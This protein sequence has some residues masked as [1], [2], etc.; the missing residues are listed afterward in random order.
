MNPIFRLGQV[1]AAPQRQTPRSGGGVNLSGVAAEAQAAQN[2][3]FAVAAEEAKAAGLARA[4]ERIASAGGGVVD[5]IKPPRMDESGYIAKKAEY[6]ALSNA[7]LAF[8]ASTLSLGLGE[9]KRRAESGDGDAEKF[10]ENYA[11]GVLEGVADPANK[12]TLAAQSGRYAQELKFGIARMVS[13][14]AEM[15]ARGRDMDDIATLAKG[16]TLS[17][18]QLNRG[19]LQA[20]YD[21]LTPKQQMGEYG[22]WVK[23]QLMEADG[24][25]VAS[26]PKFVDDRI[27]GGI[28]VND[29]VREARDWAKD[30]DEDSGYTP[31]MIE[32]AVRR[33]WALKSVGAQLNAVNEAFAK[34]IMA[35]GTVSEEERLAYDS[36]ELTAP[37][38]FAEEFKQWQKA[39]GD[40]LSFGK[41]VGKLDGD[42]NKQINDA[43]RRTEG[44]Y[45]E[46]EAVR[47]KQTEENIG[48]YF[49]G[50]SNPGAR[51]QP[52]QSRETQET[53]AANYQNEELNEDTRQK[54]AL[55]G[56]L[57]PQVYAAA[58]EAGEG[59]TGEEWD[60][61]VRTALTLNIPEHLAGVAIQ[62]KDHAAIV[63]MARKDI[64]KR[65][66][67]RGDWDAALDP[68]NERIGNALGL[69]FSKK[70]DDVAAGVAMVRNQGTLTGVE[71]MAA[72]NYLP[73]LPDGD[74]KE[75]VRDLLMREPGNNG[76]S[77]AMAAMPNTREPEEGDYNAS[78]T[79]V[80]E[81]GVFRD[82]PMMEHLIAYTH[83]NAVGVVGEKAPAEELREE[84]ARQ[85]NK[86][87][88]I[89]AKPGKFGKM[90]QVVRVKIF[91]NQ[92]YSVG[93]EMGV[94][95]SG[96]IETHAIIGKRTTAVG[97]NELTKMAFQ[98]RVA[99][100]RYQPIVAFDRNDPRAQG[101]FVFGWRDTVENAI[102]QME[103]GGRFYP[104]VTITEP[105]AILPKTAQEADAEDISVY[106]GLRM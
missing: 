20:K 29:M 56:L 87:P 102:V 44:L 48:N 21:G 96:A 71:R 105:D 34:K 92:N 88:A 101:N 65:I 51:A 61:A 81:N 85:L 42:H 93:T 14:R 32:A 52:A 63:E 58:R 47:K 8:Y 4:A 30:L 77:L 60:E 55:I 89:T 13:E 12:A 97:E 67:Q 72:I 18:W 46:A 78:L 7:N 23:K 91:P 27:A 31:E 106:A 76:F 49:V 84:H 37:E 22:K 83:A 53:L 9:A 98:E 24:F 95:A 68:N 40:R 73:R 2:D 3:I 11:A 54:S 94:V 25:A 33:A 36:L 19:R 16:T 90:A 38:L 6:D 1:A 15:T 100:G 57:S 82:A 74:A 5:G 43:A 103:K 35:G 79:D 86:H 70:P 75:S 45:K 66:E 69:L 59:K 10:Y 28:G 104:L 26:I 41:E 39:G 62:P 50:L 99:S 64:M 80:Q 17:N